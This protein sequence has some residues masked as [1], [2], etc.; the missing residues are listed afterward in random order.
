M[1]LL[2]AKG[3]VKSCLSPR[4]VG[5][6]KK[7]LGP[8]LRRV[9]ARNLPALATLT[10]TDK[11]GAHWYAGHYQAHFARLRRRRLKVLEIG[12]GG[13]DDPLAGGESLRMWKSYFPNAD[14][15]GV[16]IVDKRALQER[17]VT[18]FQGSQDDPEFLAHV[19]GQMGGLDVV[20]DD[21]SHRNAH[22][23]RTFEIL[24]P[25]LAD[26]GIYAVEDTQTSYWPHFGGSSDELNDPR[27][28]MGFFKSLVDGLNHREFLRRG[29]APS[30]YDEH[31]VALHF[32]HNLV[33]VYKGANKEASL[34]RPR[35][36][37]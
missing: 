7:A 32:Y 14:I 9:F 31:I 28:T 15:Y 5:F 21:G 26:G 20:I 12:V 29:Y 25:L 34:N 2:P 4:Q 11:W 27:T 8:F 33:F 3:L 16:D 37:G 13:F 6:L 36:A 23:L 19:V 18:I 22:V 35:L 10:G 24:F 17:R 30:Y 1:D